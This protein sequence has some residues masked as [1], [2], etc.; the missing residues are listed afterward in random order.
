MPIQV[1]STIRLPFRMA[2]VY[3]IAVAGTPTCR[4]SLN[5]NAFA[6]CGN[7]PM[8]VAGGL[9]GDWYIDLPIDGVTMFEASLDGAIPVTVLFIPED[10]YTT[11][12]A[13]AQSKLLKMASASLQFGDG[14]NIYDVYEPTPAGGG[15]PAK[16]GTLT[17]L[18]GNVYTV[19]LV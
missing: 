9:G 16:I 7:S 12:Y 17:V 4:R 10:T 13:N 18:P 19:A 5:G 6:V 14:T 15:T 11:G 3:G 8:A 2:D 1:G